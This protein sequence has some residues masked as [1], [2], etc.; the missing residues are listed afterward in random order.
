MPTKSIF[1]CYILLFRQ[2]VDE[3][4]ASINNKPNKIPIKPH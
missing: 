2:L 1:Y 3:I 4:N